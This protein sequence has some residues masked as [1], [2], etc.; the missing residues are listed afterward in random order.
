MGSAEA[1]AQLRNQIVEDAKRIAEK[2]QLHG[3]KIDL[4]FH[5]GTL[6]DTVD[7]TQRLLEEIDSTHVR[8]YWQSPHDQTVDERVAGMRQILPWV[9]N[10]HVF[11]W[12]E[13]VQQ[14]L[15]NGRAD[16]S[17]YLDVLREAGVHRAVM[18]EFVRDSDPQQFLQDAEVLKQ[19]LAPTK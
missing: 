4:E 15:M 14:P 13:R 1:D 6:T 17:I 2:A 16:W 10:V 12:I 19:L 7:S 9:A 3:I 5:G 18:L 11:H 8:S